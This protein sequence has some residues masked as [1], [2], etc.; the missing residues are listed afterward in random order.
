M[1]DAADLPESTNVDTFWADLHN[2]KQIG[3]T[4]PLYANLLV[5]VRALL[6]LPASN[7]D[8][9]FQWCGRLT[10]KIGVT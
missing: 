10:V 8:G 7:A 5:L 9:A 6:A 1:A 4:A 2:I 3:S